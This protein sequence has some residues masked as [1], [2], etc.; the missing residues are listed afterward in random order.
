MDSM[1]MIMT[2]IQVYH[3]EISLL[4]KTYLEHL[5]GHIWK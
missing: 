3:I 1:D 5:L 2:N 4:M